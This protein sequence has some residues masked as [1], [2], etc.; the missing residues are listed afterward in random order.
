VARRVAGGKAA[1]WIGR[2]SFVLLGIGLPIGARAQAPEGASAARR[3]AGRVVRPTEGDIRPVAGAWVTLHRVGPDRAGP[4]DSMRT[5]GGGRYR[6]RYEATGSEEAIYFVSASHGGIAYFTPPLRGAAVRSPDADITVFDTTSAAVPLR[7]RGRH[8]V[9]G[10]RDDDARREIIEVY[11]ISNDSSLTVVAPDTIRPVWTVL[12][13]AGARDFRMREGDV[14]EAAVRVAPG[15]LRVFAPFAPGVKQLVF[16]YHVPA[17]D[18]PLALPVERPTPVLEVLIEEPSGSASG[19][20]LAEV[21]PVS[22]EGR[23][24]RRFLASD[25]PANGV[26]TLTLPRAAMGRRGLYIA[27]IVTAILAAM[28][29]ALAR[30][31]RRRRPIGATVHVP[32]RPD[33]PERLAREIAA[34]DAAFERLPAPTREARANYD[35]RRAE[36]KE[37]L[38]RALAARTD[39]R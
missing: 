27:A 24:F 12:L 2:L 15:R 34:L 5:D 25:A 22:L 39:A 4:L 29:V 38:T 16:S 6:F 13:P 36:L 26:A 1:R 30:A 18:F 10:A 20:R 7:V 3:V 21:D 33:D 37:R 9:V 17:K 28:L 23:T 8:V 32:P 35:G 19:A 11:E 14:A 31:F